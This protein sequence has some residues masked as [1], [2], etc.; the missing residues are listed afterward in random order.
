MIRLSDL[1]PAV[2]WARPSTSTSRAD[3][4]DVSSWFQNDPASS[5]LRIVGGLNPAARGLSVQQHASQVLAQ[6]CAEPDESA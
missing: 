4:Q 5:D 6:L 3:T 1:H 2:T